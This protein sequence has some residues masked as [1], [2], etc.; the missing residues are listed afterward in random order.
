MFLKKFFNDLAATN[1][2]KQSSRQMTTAIRQ[3]NVADIEKAWN[4]VE[5]KELFVARHYGALVDEALRTDDIAVFNAVFKARPDPNY[6]FHAGCHAVVSSYEEHTP[7]LARAI[8]RGAVNIALFLANHA[9]L[10]LNA[11]EISEYSRLPFE[12]KR[13]ATSLLELAGRTLGMEE[14]VIALANRK[15]AAR[16]NAPR[17]EGPANG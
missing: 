1:R 8:R 7:L 16:N 4:E 12:E 10:D 6:Y 5:Q 17:P 15:I 11:R 13:E 2:L 3:K 14:V 9:D